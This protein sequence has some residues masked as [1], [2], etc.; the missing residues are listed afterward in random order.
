MATAPLGSFTACQC[1]P[2]SEESPVGHFHLVLF[3]RRLLTRAQRDR[4]ERRLQLTTLNLEDPHQAVV[5]TRRDTLPVGRKRD[6]EDRPL[7]PRKR[8]DFATLGVE[9]LG[10]I[11]TGD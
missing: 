5:P 7:V 11:L 1:H 3:G 6:R 10:V 8:G 4:T 2:I 9:D